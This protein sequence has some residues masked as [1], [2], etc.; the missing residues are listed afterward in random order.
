MIFNRT[1]YSVKGYAGPVFIFGQLQKR[2]KAV[3]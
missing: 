3:A 2:I 1:S